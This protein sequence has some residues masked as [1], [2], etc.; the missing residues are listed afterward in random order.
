MINLSDAAGGIDIEPL[1]T[2]T[3]DLSFE[4]GDFSPELMAARDTV[5]SNQAEEISRE[6]TTE[7]CQH[8]MDVISQT[9]AIYFASGSARINQ[10]ESAPV[11]DEVAQFFNRYPSVSM[12]I[13]GHTDSDG[14]AAYNQDLSE[15][16]AVAVA[17]A[18]MTRNVRDRRIST[19]GFGEASPVD[20]NT[21]AA[22]KAKTVASNSGVPNDNE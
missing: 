3:F 5:A 4:G 15:R 19:A 13:S 18:L 1:G 14:S 7:K 12:L 16:R 6:L 22:A 10:A 21:T 8:R 2:V 17:Q 11:F 9:R 20:V